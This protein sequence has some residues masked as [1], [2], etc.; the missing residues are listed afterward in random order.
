MSTEA[1]TDL[2]EHIHE[3]L[4]NAIISHDVIGE[5]IVF[6]G[7]CQNIIEI[8]EFLRNDRECDFSI[9]I[10]VCGVDYPERG[11]ERF[12]IVYQLLSLSQNNRVRVKITTSEEQ[13]VPSIVNVYSTAGWLE[14][15]IW[16]MYG[17][18]F[19]GNPDLRRILTDYGFEGHPLRK[20]FPLTGYVEV[21]YDEE[22]RR[23][24]YEPV[25]LAQDFRYF[26]YLSPWEGMTDVQLP[27]DEKGTIP[28]FGWVD[29]NANKDKKAS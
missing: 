27:G 10:D 3:H 28:A 16:D 19:K 8:L 5:E 25:K 29:S 24:V 17:V 15:E 9:L 7:K 1:L 20:D 18:Y 26:D 23:V 4:E 2:A 21:R 12:E 11:K 6:V 22:Q 13:Q 14:R